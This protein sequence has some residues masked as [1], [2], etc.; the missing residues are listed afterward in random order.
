[1]QRL[2]LM[3]HGEAE[4]PAP[5][6]Q[7]FD[8][9]LDAEGRREAGL[10]AAALAGAGLEPDLALVSAA[11][12]TRETWRTVAEALGHA[13]AAREDR[14]LYAASA[15]RLAAAALEAAPDARILML[16]GHN[17]GIHQYAIHLAQ[18]AGL[19]ENEARSLYERFPTGSA[20][21]FAFDAHGQPGFER[22]F[23]VKDLKARPA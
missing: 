3:R 1:M 23:L 11:R 12:R 10:I 9:A 5:G 2:I 6:L 22:L 17:P 21:V 19:G 16:V 7:D 20:A 14:S 8:R 18:Q 13:I 15:A 4:R